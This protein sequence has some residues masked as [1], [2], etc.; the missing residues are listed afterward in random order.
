MGSS[1]K[2]RGNKR[3]KQGSS[4]YDDKTEKT[5][6]PLIESAILPP[7]EP[8]KLIKEEILIMTETNEFDF[9]NDTDVQEEK[10]SSLLP[11]NQA[12]S[13]IN[14]GFC[15]FG[16]GGGKVLKSFIDLGFN[17]A[18]LFN[19]T[20]KDKPADV[21]DRHL[22]VFPNSD[23]LGK[24]VENGRK[25]FKDN[26]ALIE[27][28][29][30]TKIGKV[31]LLCV[32]CCGGSG[33][34]SSTGAIKDI[35]E[36][37]MKSNGGGQV[38]YIVS[39]P[40][41]QE[42]LNNTV[43]NNSDALLKDLEGET[44]VV[45]DNE[46]QTSILRGKVG[47]SGLYPKANESFA[48]LFWQLLKLSCEKSDLSVCDSEDLKKF[49]EAK[50]RIFLGSSTNQPD[51]KLGVNI[52]QKCID[53]SPCPA[54]KNKSNKGI[55]LQVIGEEAS[56]DP[57]VSEHLNASVAYTGARCDTLFTG[58]Y[59]RKGLNGIVSILGFSGL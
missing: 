51:D 46:R 20:A 9:I 1:I 8:K 4:F 24:N 55:L 21:P 27:D 34:G 40:T 26:S 37:Y 23:G 13:S 16:G 14:V 36:R 11:D 15:A 10:L 39:T 3:S 48:K 22:V 49:L 6:E 44:I 38:L 32:I 29:L 56:N 54:P 57:A 52:F 31:E 18:I 17:K 2:N 19:S 41:N 7:I 25:L 28:T 5:C 42:N 12:I 33:S 50:G 43:K 47:I 45:I 59:V 58:V 53:T 30:R 35:F